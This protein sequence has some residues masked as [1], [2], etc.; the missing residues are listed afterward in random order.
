VSE[1]NLPSHEILVIEDDLMNH[2]AIQVEALVDGDRKRLQQ[3]YQN[4]TVELA[5]M[6]SLAR[7][8]MER[9]WQ[10]EQ[11]LDEVS[12]M[13]DLV[14]AQLVDQTF[15]EQQLAA[16]EEIANI[17]QQ[18][19]SHL[20][21]KLIVLEQKVGEAQERDQAYQGMLDAAETLTK[22]QP[23][24]RDLPLVGDP[25]IV[26]LKQQLAEVSAQLAKRT[27]TQALLHQAC[28]ELEGERERNLARIAELERQA[29]EMQEQILRQA[30]Q[31]SEYET[32]V[33]HWKNRCQSIQ[34]QVTQ[35]KANLPQ[36]GEVPPVVMEALEAI[37]ALAA[38][39]EQMIRR[40]TTAHPELK[41]D[42][43]DFLTHRR[44]R[45]RQA[46]KVNRE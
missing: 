4:L 17:Q 11:A 22:A 25:E 28:Q 8:Q 34:D 44:Y 19:I 1:S 18:A 37:Q 45:N 15:L 21:Q 9:I 12:K 30:Q 2:P 14:K 3:A 42:L 41:P 36:L 13:F 10:L 40:S 31:A 33:Q 35:L 27:A 43:P 46:A 26:K 39:P 6:R 5:Q 32:A 38:P 29:A 20:K 7:S 23:V 16:T 24:S